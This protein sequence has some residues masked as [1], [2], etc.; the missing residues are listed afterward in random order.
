VAIDREGHRFW[1]RY[2]AGNHQVVL[3]E[4]EISGAEAREALTGDDALTRVLFRLQKRLT[5]AGIDAYV[6][7]IEPTSTEAPPGR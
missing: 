5:E 3:R 1:I 2:D 6:S 4:D 7:N